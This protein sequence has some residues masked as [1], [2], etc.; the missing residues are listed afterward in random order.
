MGAPYSEHVAQA[1]YAAGMETRAAVL[2]ETGAPLSVEQVELDEP[3]AGEV[4]VRIAAAGVCRSDLHVI[5]GVWMYDLPMVLGHEGSGVVDAVGPGV[6]APRVGDAV[7]LSWV[8]SCG[9]CRSCASGSPALCEIGSHLHRMPDGTSRLRAHGQELGHFMATACFAEHV[10][11][12]ATQAVELP[13]GADLEVAAL[14][15]CAAMTGVGAV[16]TT[17]EARPGERAVVFGCGGVGQCI[18]QGLR[19]VGAHPIVAVDVSEKAL[20]LARASGATETVL[21]GSEDDRRAIK[22]ATRGGADIAFEALG[23][24]DTIEAAYAALA[25]GGRAVIVGMP[26]RDATVT[27]N[28]FSLAG[29]GLSL[30]GS[31]YGSARPH[32]DVPRLVELEDAG[33]LSLGSLIARHYSLDEINGAYDDLRAGAPGRGVIA[34]A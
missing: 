2:W 31:L 7:A 13:E 19:A 28:A 14:I 30:L 22:R 26:A 5:D 29:Q 9:R 15:G 24:T 23:R 16:F 11:V 32:L 34:F 4:R 17:A 20:E 27:I 10:V 3:Q 33:L 25:P 21:A 1:S 18:V 6:L 8:T 12:P